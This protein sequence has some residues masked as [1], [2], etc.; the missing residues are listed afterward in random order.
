MILPLDRLRAKLPRIPL[1]LPTGRDRHGYVLLA[2]KAC[3]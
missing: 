2:K 3:L 1:H